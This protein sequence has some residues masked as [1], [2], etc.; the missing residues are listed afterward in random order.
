VNT[1]GYDTLLNLTDSRYRLSTIVAKRAVQL[2][3]GLPSTLERNEYPANRDGTSNNVVAIALQEVLQDKDIVWGETLPSNAELI[4]AFE[5][6]KK[7]DPL[8]YSI[9]KYSVRN[10][11]PSTLGPVS[12]EQELVPSSL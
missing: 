8:N 6:D 9:S 5:R 1:I 7:S 11:A 4:K 10:A 12:N 3:K 2:K